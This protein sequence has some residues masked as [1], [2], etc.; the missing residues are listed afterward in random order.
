[1]REVEVEVHA[2]VGGRDE[3]VGRLYCHR[4]RGVESATFHYDH[5][6]LASPDAYALEPLLPLRSG[7]FQTAAGLALFGC[8]CDSAPD[9]WGR[10]LIRRAQARHAIGAARSVGDG[11]FL[12]GV[13]DDAR[14]GALRFRIPGESGFVADAQTGVP[15][16][17]ELPRLLDAS[18]RLERDGADDDDLALLLRAGSSLGGA[19]PKAHVVTSGG[20][21]AI[22]KFPSAV[23]DD[24]DVMAWERVC[25]VLAERAGIRV[26]GSDLLAVAGRRVLILERFDRDG[27]RRIGFVSAMT[28]LEARDGDVRSY[29]EIA[30]MIESFSP[31]PTAELRELW[32]RVAFS[33]LVS[34][35]DDHLRNHGFLHTG[36]GGWVLS[37]AF[38]INPN[39]DGG[40]KY[41][42]TAIDLDDTAA[43][44]ETLLGVA[45]HFRLDD[46]A[47]RR[48]LGAVERAVS[49]WRSTAAAVGIA[50]AEIEQ[51]ETAFQNDQRAVAQRL[52]RPGA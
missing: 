34:N 7:S 46:D 17:I 40:P 36:R 12:L 23:A 45:P 26:P 28:V 27:D 43:S 6:W 11:D 1:M 41:L 30:E 32:S 10:A 3:F 24:W 37:P 48:V 22:A 31:S 39:P 19:R 51:M 50:D 8:F 9:R 44:I 4:R 29:L 14:Q 47:A 15:H 38:D 49:G 52:T 2:Q 35:T 13:R 21:L 5:S 42:S 33:I 16:L 20:R 18:A 25:L